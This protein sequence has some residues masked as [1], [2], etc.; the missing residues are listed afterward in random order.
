MVGMTAGG[1]CVGVYYEG[2]HPVTALYVLVQIVTTVGYGDFTVES[3]AMKLFMTAYV[4]FGLLAVARV[5]QGL[6]SRLADLGAG[7]VRRTIEALHAQLLGI[8]LESVQRSYSKWHGLA[9]SCAQ[10]GAAVLVGAAFHRFH[11]HCT[12]WQNGVAKLEGCVESDYETCQRTGGHTT[13]WTSAI[14]M[15]VITLTTVGFGD[16]VPHTLA[17]HAFGILW[18]L[19]GVAVTASFL[20]TAG[21]FLFEAEEGEEQ[22]QSETQQQTGPTAPNVFDMA[23]GA[24]FNLDR[25]R[26][27]SLTR[28]EYRGFALL[29][30]GLVSRELLDQIDGEFDTLARDADAGGDGGGEA[31]GLVSADRIATAA[32]GAFKLD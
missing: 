22:S 13:S 2:W 10:F 23:M 6:A 9:A 20:S 16:H 17:G 30:R 8:S 25:T 31:D 12:C 7:R 28:A 5:Y 27:G 32:A 3:E 21:D 11:E 1:V 29:R 18:M 19:Y 4:L 14:Y 24:L 26:Q 15:S